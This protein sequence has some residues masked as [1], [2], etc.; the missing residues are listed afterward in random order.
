MEVRILDP[1]VSIFEYR[2]TDI[3]NAI[4][5]T[6]PCFNPNCVP[7]ACLWK[8]YFQ[9]KQKKS[10]KNTNKN[11]EI[12]FSSSG[13]ARAWHAG[14]QRFDPAWLHQFSPSRAVNSR[15]LVA[16]KVGRAKRP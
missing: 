15:N 11:N 4:Q 6:E 7:F 12:V 5:H 3:R 9:K 10:A 2:K 8:K 13:G 14:G 16:A 1:T